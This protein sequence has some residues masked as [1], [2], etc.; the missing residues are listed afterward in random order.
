MSTAATQLPEA[1]AVT[2]VS[3]TTTVFS[4]STTT[5]LLPVPVQLLSPDT[6]N[7]AARLFRPGYVGT[8]IVEPELLH[9]AAEIGAGRFAS[10]KSGAYRKGRD[11]GFSLARDVKGAAGE[12][13]VRQLLARLAERG[14]VQFSA[15][16]A[17][18]PDTAADLQLAGVPFDVKTAAHRSAFPGLQER[19]DRRLIVKNSRLHKYL[20]AGIDYLIFVYLESAR[21]AHVY[22]EL[23]DDA[24]EWELE[25]DPWMAKQGAYRWVA[26][27]D[28]LP[29]GQVTAPA[30][31]T[32]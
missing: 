26:A 24:L 32:A 17:D 30:V 29:L 2:I 10:G 11:E 7:L 20:R 13:I 27:A 22:V 31:G 5:E 19:D 3:T 28:V 23:T 9:Q 8:V 16:L 12:L 4:I 25:D 14:F 1:V 15:L 21:V 18:L 6:P